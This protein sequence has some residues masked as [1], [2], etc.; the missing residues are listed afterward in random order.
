MARR[1]ICHIIGANHKGYV[2]IGKFGIDVIHIN[3]F[4]VWNVCFGKQDVHMPGIRPA[5]GCMA[6]LIVAPRSLR[7][8]ANSLTPCCAC[9]AAIPYPGTMITSFALSKSSAASFG[10]PER[11]VFGPTSAAA[12]LSEGTAFP[13]APKSTLVM[14]RFIAL[15]MRIESINPDAPST[16][17]PIINI[18]F[19]SAKPRREAELPAYEFNI[20]ITVGIS[21]APMGRIRNT[22]NTKDMA[23][24]I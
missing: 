23:T 7:M 22:P 24:I 3:Q 4:I 8:S 17:P 13:N 12:V 6:Y 11:T 10:V 9:A 19:E 16:A 18:L 14:E 20:A 2:R 1:R 5:T 15:H 21:A